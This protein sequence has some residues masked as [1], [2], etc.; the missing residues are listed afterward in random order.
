MD[1]LWLL[2]E[3]RPKPSVVLQII[4]M[5]CTDFADSV[6]VLGEIKIKPIIE[7]GFFKFIYVVENLSVGK[8]H[9]I[10]IKT[11]VSNRRELLQLYN[12]WI[13]NQVIC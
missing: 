11:D 3:E 8:A 7:N 4:N 13:E 12:K 9:N 5:Y 10:F 1:N 6:S 2:T